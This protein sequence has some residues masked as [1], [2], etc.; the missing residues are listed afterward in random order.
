MGQ[1]LDVLDR[2]GIAIEDD[3]ARVVIDTDIRFVDQ[4]NQLGGERA[5]GH[6]TTMRF[7]TDSDA[8]RR[9]FIAE[10][11]NSGQKHFSLLVE[12][13]MRGGVVPT[14]A[15]GDKGNAQLV[16]DVQRFAELCHATVAGQIGVPGKADRG[17]PIL[18]QQVLDMR[19]L[20][21]SGVAAD[22]LGPARAQKSA[23]RSLN[24]AFCAP[25]SESS[26]E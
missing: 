22:M 23:R 8:H 15:G 21:V 16:G 11:P 1:H 9:R 24:P 6:Q 19:E 7:Q 25:A 4:L 10:R 14:G 18:L 20:F 13:A 12:R 26:S 5:V 17:L 3:I 2:V